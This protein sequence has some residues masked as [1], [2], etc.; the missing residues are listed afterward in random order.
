MFIAGRRFEFFGYTD[1][2]WTLSYLPTCGVA[3]APYVNEE[4]GTFKYAE[5]LKV[6]DYLGCGLPI[7]ITRVPDIANEIDKKGIPFLATVRI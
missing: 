4:K 6:K 2:D 3:L 5:P 1:H 7:I